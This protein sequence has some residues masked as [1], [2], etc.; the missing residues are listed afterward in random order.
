MNAK[1]LW[2]TRQSLQKVWFR[3]VLFAILAVGAVL[4]SP[5][6][7]KILPAAIYKNI[8]YVPVE[9]LLKILSSSMLAVTTFSLSIAVSAFAAASSSATPRATILLQKDTT[10]QT[11]LATF[12]GAFLFGIVGLIFIKLSI[13]GK[14]AQTGLF[15]ASLVVLGL[16]ITALLRWISHLM[17][18]GRIGDTLNRVE[19]AVADA[20]AQRVANPYLGGNPLSYV[21]KNNTQKVLSNETGYIQHIDVSAL[22]EIAEKCNIKIYL[23]VIPGSFVYKTSELLIVEGADLDELQYE[24]LRYKFTLGNERSFEQDPRFG[25]LVMSEIASKALSPAVNDPGTAINV[26]GRLVRLLSIW[27]VNGQV[28]V[29]YLH[30]FVPCISCEDLLNDA[31]R[32][33]ARDGASMVEVQLRLHK[34]LAA[35][36]QVIPEFS[37]AAKQVGLYALER[38][39]NASLNEQDVALL[40]QALK[41]YE[42]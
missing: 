19:D 15:V 26:I 18:F 6:I 14:P 17:N 39:K 25:L 37:Q 9:E 21:P 29:K 7:V 12:L 22:N 41:K 5:I 23:S 30:I 33:I 36:K 2:I 42:S 24:Q 40:E 11:V 28:E 8:D 27:Q 13:T 20:I 34:A 38:A 3:V 35:L 32:A 31:Y 1:L 10:T 4:V 16:V